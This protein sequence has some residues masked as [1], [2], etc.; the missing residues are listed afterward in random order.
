M[1]MLKVANILLIGPKCKG[2]NCLP[3]NL[4]SLFILKVI[5]VMLMYDLYVSS[6]LKLFNRMSHK[7][8]KKN[9]VLS[10]LLFLQYFPHF[11]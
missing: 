10:K 11:G 9:T 3:T 2:G 1:K 7:H 5:A 6:L 8:L 4:T